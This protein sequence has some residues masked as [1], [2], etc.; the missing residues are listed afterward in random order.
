MTKVNGT[1]SC[2]NEN[3]LQNLLKTEL[4]FPGLVTPDVGGQTN[5]YTSAQG[6]LDYGSSSYWTNTTVQEGINNGSF[7]Q[8]LLD[9]KVI[10]NVIGYYYVGLDNGTQPAL[11]SSTD[12]VDVRAN[13]AS[14]VREVGG[15]AMALL[16][17]TNNA[18][19]LSKPLS[20]A[21][22]GSGAGPV[23]AGPK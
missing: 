7:S 18:L 8:A 13:H 1:L 4:G 17:N 10:R 19:P 12:Y 9:D 21:M 14:I 22:F 20:I 23:M 16:K 6:G 5:A 2:E 11:C 3:L 15:A